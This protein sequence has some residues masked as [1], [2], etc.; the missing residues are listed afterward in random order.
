MD[1]YLDWLTVKGQLTCNT[2]VTQNIEDYVACQH[3]RATWSRQSMGTR[4]SL[5]FDDDLRSLLQHYSS[6]GD[7][8]YTMTTTLTWGTPDVEK[9]HPPR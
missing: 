6:G 3:S 9:V 7:I 4:R 5:E 2:N 1:E 8:Q